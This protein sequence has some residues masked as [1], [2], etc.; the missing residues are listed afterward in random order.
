MYS[1]SP[2]S[3]FIVKSSFESLDVFHFINLPKKTSIEYDDRTKQKQQ[4]IEKKEILIEILEIFSEIKSSSG[5]L[6]HSYH[7]FPQFSFF[8]CFHFPNCQWGGIASSLSHMIFT[9][10]LFPL[11]ASYFCFLL[12]FLVRV[13]FECSRAKECWFPLIQFRRI[14]CY[15]QK[16]DESSKN[17]ILWIGAIVATF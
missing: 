8:V 12:A 11:K 15:L 10:E 3:L 9:A 6:S 17:V 4:K 14:K 13:V 1:F 2:F 5:F 7:A 16:R